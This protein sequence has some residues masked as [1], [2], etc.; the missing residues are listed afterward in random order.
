MS[1]LPAPGTAAPP[2]RTVAPVMSRGWAFGSVTMRPSI[3]PSASCSSA[4]SDSPPPLETDEA[5]TIVLSGRIVRVRFP[6]AGSIGAY[7]SF[8]AQNAS[9]MLS[10]TFRPQSRS[11]FCCEKMCLYA[12]RCGNA[13]L[14]AASA[15]AVRST[16]KCA[17]RPASARG[18]SRPSIRLTRS[19]ARSW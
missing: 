8:S 11:G 17:R 1:G 5:M 15:S 18:T 6:D 2:K 16:A 13:A 3:S 10:R 7:S 4:C 12:M 9:R 19:V 14:Y